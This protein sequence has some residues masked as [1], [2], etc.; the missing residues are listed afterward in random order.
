MPTYDYTCGAC[1]KT[2]EIFHG[3][4][5]GARRKCPLCGKL[6]LKRQIGSGSGIIFKG[7]GFFST[8]YKKPSA[9]EPGSES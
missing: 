9:P 8:D 2:T 1:G 5:E 3:M 7:S 6:K 4:N